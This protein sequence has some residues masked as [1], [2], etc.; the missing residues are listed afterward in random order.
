ME[1]SGEHDISLLTSQAN[2]E[3]AEN[4]LWFKLNCRNVSEVRKARNA[5]R[6]RSRKRLF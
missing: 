1:Y 3:V 5:M 2:V 4:V 6:T